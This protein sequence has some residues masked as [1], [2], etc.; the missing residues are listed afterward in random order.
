MTESIG[1]YFRESSNISRGNWNVRN[2]PG[3]C[4]R[5]KIAFGTHRFE[6]RAEV[7]GHV[8]VGGHRRKVVTFV[9]TKSSK[10]LVHI[11]RFLMIQFAEDGSIPRVCDEREVCLRLVLFI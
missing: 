5:R 3:T 8:V 11:V 7:G 2:I 6:L 4:Q 1:T 9:L 10:P